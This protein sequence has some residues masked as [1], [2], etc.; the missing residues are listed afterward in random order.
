MYHLTT[1][2]MHFKSTER[3]NEWEVD[4]S[5]LNGEQLEILAQ[6]QRKL[7]EPEKLRPVNLRSIDRKKVQEKL[8]S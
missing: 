3:E 8:Q 6:L 2:L 1:T 7:N 5:N 4:D